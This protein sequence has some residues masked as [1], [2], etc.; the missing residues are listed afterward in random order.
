MS[1]DKDKTNTGHSFDFDE[2]GMFMLAQI[3]VLGAA[4]QVDRYIQALDRNDKSKA[5]S[6]LVQFH[7]V[8]CLF[9]DL[10]CISEYF[11]QGGFTHQMDKVWKQVRHHI[12]HDLRDKS[13]DEQAVGQTKRRHKYLKLDSRM[14]SQLSF[15]KDSI[16][17]GADM[18]VFV[19]DIKEYIDWA[20]EIMGDYFEQGKSTG[21]IVS[22]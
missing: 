11:K 2:S 22:Q 9:E 13:T 18:P 1:E 8:S 5:T 3:Y 4:M 10:A 7:E 6:L 20:E 12:R 15:T 17:I 14:I 16:N 21:K 19:I